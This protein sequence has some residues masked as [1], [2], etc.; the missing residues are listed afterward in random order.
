MTI[1]SPSL[2]VSIQPSNYTVLATL[3][4]YF[5]LVLV[6]VWLLAVM[7]ASQ[8]HHLG[9]ILLYITSKEQLLWKIK[10]HKSTEVHNRLKD[11]YT[12]S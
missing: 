9:S 5:T 11:C 12:I 8:S 3:A 1:L 4:Y 2:V 6:N 10:I 7:F